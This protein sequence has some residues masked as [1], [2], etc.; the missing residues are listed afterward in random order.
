MIYSGSYHVRLFALVNDVEND[1]IEEDGQMALEKFVDV[2]NL[3][4]NDESEKLVDHGSSP[5]SEMDDSNRRLSQE[6]ASV[7]LA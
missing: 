1:P 6:R 3:Q 5:V 4:N 7:F 2:L